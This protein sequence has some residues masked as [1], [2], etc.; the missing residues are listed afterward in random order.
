MSRRAMLQ[1]LQRLP[2]EV[3]F[4][5]LCVCF[6]RLHPLISGRT[7]TAGCT[8]STKVREENKGTPSC[9]FSCVWVSTQ[10]STRTE[11]E[12][13][14]ACFLGR[15]VLC[16]ETTQS[17]HVA[18]FRPARVVDPLQDPSP[19]WQDTCS[20]Q[21]RSQLQRVAEAVDPRALVWRGS[22]VPI[23][24]GPRFFFL[25]T[26]VGHYD[27]VRRLLEGSG[28]ATGSVGSHPKSHTY[29]QRGF[30]SSTALQRAAILIG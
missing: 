28:E 27:Y 13:E 20:E 12:R 15:R 17:W 26:P 23:S 8:Q 14:V 5:R 10:D 6:T 30:F 19:C 7:M 29:S 1:G 21:S 11:P 18:Q 9:P 2:E 16:V 4:S 25:G 3:P 24:K 22:E